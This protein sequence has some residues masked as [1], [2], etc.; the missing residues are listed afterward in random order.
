[1]GAT[2]RRGMLHEPNRVAP[3]VTSFRVVSLDGLALAAVFLQATNLYLP[4]TYIAGFT[5]S[6]QANIAFS[7]F[8]V[9]YLVARNKTLAELHS[10]VLAGWAC[11]LGVAPAVVM[12][13][14][15]ID[16]T[17]TTARLVYWI[18]FAVLFPLLLLVAVVLWARWGSRLSTPFFLACIVAT[19]FGFF[20]N[21]FDYAFLRK[22]LFYSSNPFAASFVA[23]RTLGFY[24]HPNE[25]ALSLVLCI[26]SLACTREFLTSGYALQTIATTGSLAG[27][28]IT[29]SRTSLILV[30]LVLAWYVRNILRVHGEASSG[31]RKRALLAPLIPVLVVVSSAFAIQLITSSRADLAATVSARM[32]SISTL[33]SGTDESAVARK[34]VVT[35]YYSDLVESPLIG[36]GP[37][38]AAYRIAQ[39]SYRSV[40]QNSWLEWAMRFGVLYAVLIAVMIIFTYRLALRVG[41]SQPLLLSYARLVLTIFVL[42]TFSM[43]D[44]FWMRQPVLVVGVLL[45]VLL[46]DG[47]KPIDTAPTKHSRVSAR[48]VR[49]RD[50]P[51]VEPANRAL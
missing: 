28:V 44:L 10:G 22:I 37:D 46:H 1:M 50:R 25:A 35:Q 29:G 23:E 31:N 6:R 34:S 51:Y 27:V 41:R 48:A 30:A 17:V 4:L 33:A 21:W 32:A 2:V 13:L 16:N 40:S 26:A 11:T 8:F 15:L 45:G 7:L 38:F 9:F 39:G 5:N 20:V 49:T 14:Q 12:A 42:V 3:A 18:T 47:S 24:P 36:R 19:W 43:V